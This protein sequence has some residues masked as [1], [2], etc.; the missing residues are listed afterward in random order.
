MAKTMN[1]TEALTW[2]AETFEVS[3]ENVKPDTLREEIESWDS[4]GALTLMARLDEDFEIILTEDELS[5]MKAVGD[6]L[7]VFTDSRS[8]FNN[9]LLLIRQ[10]K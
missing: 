1:L 6:I 10:S 2:I 5:E 4:L 9:I 8:I 3:V 7:N